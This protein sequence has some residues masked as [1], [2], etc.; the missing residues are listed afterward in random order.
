MQVDP[1]RLSLAQASPQRVSDRA[2]RSSDLQAD[3]PHCCELLWREPQS[4]PVEFESVTQALKE[5]SRIVQQARYG[6]QM[7]QGVIYAKRNL[8][9]D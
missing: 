9:L 3:A 5:R 4:A 7:N 2:E 1:W 6:R 8:K